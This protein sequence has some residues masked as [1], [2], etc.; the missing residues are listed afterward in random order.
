MA[1]SIGRY[2]PAYHHKFDQK[3]AA[4][5]CA[6]CT[7]RRRTWNFPHLSPCSGGILAAGCAAR[8][9]RMAHL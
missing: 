3:I 5:Y 6:R 7:I 1:A 2:S 8:A 9:P 4:L